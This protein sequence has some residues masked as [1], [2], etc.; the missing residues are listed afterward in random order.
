MC[1]SLALQSPAAAKVSVVEHTV[2]TTRSSASDVIV[3]SGGAGWRDSARLEARVGATR[4]G[5]GVADEHSRDAGWRDSARP[6]ARVSATR[7]GAD[8]EGQCEI[9]SFP[10][11]MQCLIVGM[12]LDPWRL[13][14]LF[15]RK[16][17]SL[18]TGSRARF[19]FLHRL[20]SN[21]REHVSQVF[22][23]RE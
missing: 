23:F 5:A 7:D 15:F 17:F 19:T 22:G 12:Y 21:C 11:S 13:S 20:A 18:V 16:K 10:V 8:V 9:T 2:G 1:S 14:Q 6:E 4:G 3:H